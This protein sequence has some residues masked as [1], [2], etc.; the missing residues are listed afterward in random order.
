MGKQRNDNR[1]SSPPA[2]ASPFA[3]LQSLRGSLPPGAAE[4]APAAGS[5]S[6]FDTKVVI[7]RERKGRGGKTVTVVRGVL[8]QG[9]MLEDFASEMRR[10]LGT[11]GSV[12]DALIVVAGDQV[13]RAA[14]WLRARGASRIVI[15]N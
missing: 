3:A 5:T 4:P 7:S 8:L 12:E 1:T 2:P 9:A 11:G 14:A 15:A 6:C 10:A 13:Q